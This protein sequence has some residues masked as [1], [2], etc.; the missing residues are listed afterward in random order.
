MN[1]LELGNLLRTEPDLATLLTFRDLVTFGDLV[2][3]LRDEISIV[4]LP[5]VTTPPPT[6]PAKIHNF[7]RDVFSLTDHDTKRLWEILRNAAWSSEVIGTLQQRRA[8]ALIPLFLKYGPAHGISMSLIL[9]YDALTAKLHLTA[10]YNLRPPT[11]VCLDPKC[12]KK[13][14]RVA[15]VNYDVKAVVLSQPV[16]HDAVVY[17]RDLGPIPS[18]ATSLYCQIGRAHV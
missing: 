7:F 9:L 11:R 5:D 2:L 10:F 12:N 14:A 15:S 17:T 3:W 13:R 18:Q 6:L 1:L 16:S 4:Q 8:E